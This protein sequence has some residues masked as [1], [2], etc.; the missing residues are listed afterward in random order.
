MEMYCAE[1]TL[2]YVIE[3][4]ACTLW[5]RF[6]LLKGNVCGQRRI[7]YVLFLGIHEQ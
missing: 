1:K 2:V 6:T 4:P 5:C 7:Q 3:L